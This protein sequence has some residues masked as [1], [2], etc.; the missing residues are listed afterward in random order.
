MALHLRQDASAFAEVDSLEVHLEGLGSMIPAE[1]GIYFMP[2]YHHA[3]SEGGFAGDSFGASFS[4]AVT[5]VNSAMSSSTGAG[6]GALRLR[7]FL[8]LWQQLGLG[9]RSFHAASAD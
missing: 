7:Q 6:G 8:G 5:S 1:K 3:R 4:T 9:S 2:W